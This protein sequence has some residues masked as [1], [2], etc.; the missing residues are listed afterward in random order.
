MKNDIKTIVIT[1]STRGIGFGLAD[2]FLN[3]GCAVMVSGRTQAAVKEAM[4]KL[5][6]SHEKDRVRGIPCDVIDPVQLQALWNAAVAAFGH[7]DIWINN[8][9]IA[10]ESLP[11]W[12]ITSEQLSAIV[13]T[14]LTGA[15]LGCG[16]AIR[17]MLKQGHGAVYNLEGL[18]SD[19]G[20]FV[21]GTTA[22]GTTKAALRYFD[23][24][25]AI[26]LKSKPVICG[27]IL[28]GM[29]YTNLLTGEHDGRKLDPQRIK[30]IM[31]IIGDQVE[32]VAPKIAQRV[33]ANT[34][35]GARIRMVSSGT[36]LWR[37]LAA[38]FIKRHVI[39]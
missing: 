6:E 34:I 33:L 22:Y 11:V 27:S 21:P 7:V 17:G 20:R 18:G 1:G 3:L 12:E 32:T 25:L 35:N 31:N 23:D 8:A 19:R 30:G 39:D 4:K 14:N 10:A 2:S 28:P 13:H 29:V 36:I 5:T 26:E 16:I 15:M 9:G 24:A 38:P 37:F